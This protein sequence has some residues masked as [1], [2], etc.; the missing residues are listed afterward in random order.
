MIDLLIIIFLLMQVIVILALFIL[1][2]LHIYKFT[3]QNRIIENYFFPLTMLFGI[4]AFTPLLLSY[5][6]FAVFGDDPIQIFL[7]TF[8]FTFLSYM[9]YFLVSP[10]S[11]NLRNFTSERSSSWHP[12][13][14]SFKYF[15]CSPSSSRILSTICSTIYYF[16]ATS[17][18][19]NSI[20]P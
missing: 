3:S 10:L 15:F 16:F 9:F 8:V 12:A 2:A 4:L 17:H 18:C 7:S 14:N 19:Y 20:F 1:L 11:I 6:H 13:T 5:I